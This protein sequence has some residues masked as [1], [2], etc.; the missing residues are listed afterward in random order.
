MAKVEGSVHPVAS[1]ELR[2]IISEYKS[3]LLKP[4]V[5]KGLNVWSNIYL[6]LLTLL[7]ANNEH[8]NL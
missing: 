1:L 8:G 6:V 3:C 7:S 4:C 5:D 2:S